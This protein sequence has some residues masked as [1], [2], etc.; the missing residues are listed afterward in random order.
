MGFLQGH[1]THWAVLLAVLSIPA[2]WLLAVS[3]TTSSAS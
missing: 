2:S 1:G 3:F